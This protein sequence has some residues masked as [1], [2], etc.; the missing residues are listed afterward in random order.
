MEIREGLL[1]DIEA[2]VD[3]STKKVHE[4]MITMNKKD[5]GCLGRR[6]FKI[7]RK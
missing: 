2:C 7:L 4:D 1:K 5:G 3:R 6:L